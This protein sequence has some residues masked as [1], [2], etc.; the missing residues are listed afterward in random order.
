VHT[1]EGGPARDKT[2]S[3]GVSS[4]DTGP[5]ITSRTPLPGET[6]ARDTLGTDYATLSRIDEATDRYVFEAVDAPD[7]A[8]SRRAT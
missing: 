2:A 6:V 1:T 3:R 7:D 8:P 5:K 4:G